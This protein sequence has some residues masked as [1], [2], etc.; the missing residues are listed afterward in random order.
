VAKFAGVDEFI[1]AV[2][3]TLSEARYLGVWAG[4]SELSIRGDQHGFHRRL[5]P[6]QSA[7]PPRDKLRWRCLG[8]EH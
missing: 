2:L 7:T 4:R 8:K 3:V 5:G 6:I 1:L